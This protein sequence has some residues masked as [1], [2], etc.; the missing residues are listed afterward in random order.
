ML[1]RKKRMLLTV[2]A[3][4]ILI[5]ATLAY[6]IVAVT[7]MSK[8]EPRMFE[9]I[10]EFEKLDTY[11][12]RDLTPADDAKLGTLQ[13]VASYTKEIKYEKRKYRVYAYVFNSV[14]DSQTYYQNCGCGLFDDMDFAF[15]GEAGLFS[16]ATYTAYCGTCA[17]R[18]EGGAP[19][20][21]ARAFDFITGDFPLNL[22]DMFF[23]AFWEQQGIERE[24]KRMS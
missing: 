17:Y 16:N 13:P 9:D 8:H 3:V 14:A 1:T 2:I 24:G 15:K 11:V 22:Q 7:A 19:R 23:D 6:L 18:L 10:A 21:S 4:V 12:T 5:A 20:P